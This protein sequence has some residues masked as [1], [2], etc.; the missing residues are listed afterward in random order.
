[1]KLYLHARKVIQAGD[2][3]AE[4]PVWDAEG[5]RLLWVDHAA[6]TLHEAKHGQTGSWQES[7]RWHLGR[8]LAGAL[9][10][11][12]GGLVIASGNEISLLGEAQAITHFARLDIDP[13]TCRVNDIKCDAR[14]RLWVGTFAT[15]FTPQGGLHRVD[16]DGSVTQILKSML[17]PNGLDW[18]IDGSTFYLVDSLLGTVDA[19]DFNLSAGTLDNRR[20]LLKFN[21]ADGLPN[22]MTVDWQDCLWIAHTTRG[23]VRRYTRDGALLMRVVVPVSGVTSCSFGGEEGGDLFITSRR[24]RV[25]EIIKSLGVPEELLE[26]SG[27]DA[28]ALFICQP[29]VA[30]PPAT[31]FAG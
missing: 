11:R 23:E 15:D 28:G 18:S 19:F 2:E 29:G 1:M 30:G 9:P 17:L 5:K 12:R 14:G 21:G 6:D 25:P 7:G 31:P 4:A 8:R 24:G 3:I 27:P 22:G 10:R 16:P 13:A 26:S 20:T